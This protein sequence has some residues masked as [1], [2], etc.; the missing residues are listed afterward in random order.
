MS[1]TTYYSY[2]KRCSKTKSAPI[3]EKTEDDFAIDEE[4]SSE[5]T[6]EVGREERKAKSVCDSL[7]F[8]VYRLL[9]GRVSRG[10]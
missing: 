7:I 2:N 9:G 3:N 6:E 8:D 1:N 5:R 4:N 10:L